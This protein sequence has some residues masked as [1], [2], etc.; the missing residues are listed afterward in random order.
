MNN[1]ELE[2][3]YESRKAYLKKKL[4]NSEINLDQYADSLESYRLF[5]LA[6]KSKV[7][8]EK[9][10]NLFFTRG[11]KLKITNYKVKL[12]SI[13]YEV[14]SDKGNPFKYTLPKRMTAIKTRR[15]LKQIS[16]EVDDS[17]L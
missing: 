11:I 16:K 17:K 9:L 13:E 15:K 7:W 1:K 6:I 10:T 2:Y 5:L 3:L 14:E 12:K 4:Y 8:I